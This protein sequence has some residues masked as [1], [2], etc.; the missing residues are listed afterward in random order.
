MMH[1]LISRKTWCFAALFSVILLSVFSVLQIEKNTSAFFLEKTHPA[2][3]DHIAHQ[4][5]FARTAYSTFVLLRLKEGSNIYRNDLVQG[6]E[7]I[8]KALEQINLLEHVSHQVLVEKF[9][10]KLNESGK[11]FN[12]QA[13][14]INYY[15]ALLRSNTSAK[16]EEYF[17]QYLFPIKTT[18]SLINTDNIYER[19]D[20][21]IVES[22]YVKRADWPE[23]A[24]TQIAKNGLLRGGM[25]STDERGV[26]INVEFAI[27]DE[28]TNL[29]LALV[30]KIRQVVSKT[31]NEIQVIESVHYAGGP[32][33]NNSLSEVMERDNATYFPLVILF[34]LTTLVVFYRS[35]LCA[36]YGLTIAILSILF[37]MSLMPLMDISLNI[38]TTILP[39]FIITIAVTD[40][41]HVMS[42]VTSSAQPS[43]TLTV[44]ASIRKL[45]RP[46]L[47]T[48]L[49]TGIGFLSLSLTEISNISDFGLMVAL[50]VVIAFVLS[51]TVLPWLMTLWPIK[52]IHN[53]KQGTKLIELQAR[54]VSMVSESKWPALLC[55]VLATVMTIS[56]LPALQVDQASIAAFDKKSSLRT[57]ND[58]F[59]ESGTGSVVL[60][61]WFHGNQDSA[62]L[63]PKVLSLIKEV[64]IVAAKHPYYVDS[65]SLVDFLERIHVV[66]EGDDST[67]LKLE[68]SERIRQYLLLL[69]GGSERDLDSVVSVGDYK[70]TRIALSLAQDNSAA[71]GE[72]I[73]AVEKVL[74]NRL[75]E[76]IAFSYAGY[77]S[78]VYATA[79]EVFVSQLKSLSSSLAA[80]FL[81]F[82]IVFRS[83]ST[84]VIGMLPLSAT[85][86]TMFGVMGYF[87]FP[88][89]VGSSL[90]AGIAFGIGID[91]S[92]HLIEAVR[93]V[94]FST[95]RK[96][97]IAK[98]LEQVTLPISVSAIV[99]SSGFSLL[100]LSGFKPLASL[101]L[102]IMVATLVSAAFSLVIVPFILNHL[103]QNM[104]ESI[105][106]KRA[107]PYADQSLKELMD[108]DV[109]VIKPSNIPTPKASKSS[110]YVD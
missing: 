26:L 80:I 108:E 6:L 60:N 7:R 24:K 48:S 70:Q 21:L 16:V 52:P 40:S 37:T 29:N 76:G 58:K 18:K 102:L 11:V 15:N 69:E 61:I 65:A 47:L 33:L 9:D 30:N 20:E 59:I 2:R 101:G 56:G 81:I 99:L 91:Y 54:F 22:S 64:Q 31:T 39:V 17:G 68:D 12:H 66:L 96:Q 41:I 45:F 110:E 105:T 86:A 3:A 42:D 49:T 19:A 46:M 14:A 95:N 35:V 106:N 67:S 100:L 63:S 73:A 23:S 107:D 74:S 82:L 90:V 28:D 93:R 98:A 89:D 34:V 5:I 87:D 8:H 62:I 51:V 27:D 55:F 104:F 103:P 1:T 10:L 36:V 72:I 79:E 78:I 83:L 77:A 50:S 109:V 57:D 88:L 92:I 43:N 75:P 32:V 85:L 84:A 94:P 71:I 4:Q 53:N 38:V 25:F 13:E 44:K 97:V